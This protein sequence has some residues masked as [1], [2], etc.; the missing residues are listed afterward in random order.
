MDQKTEVRG[1]SVKLCVIL[2]TTLTIRS[3][4]CIPSPTFVHFFIKSQ[5]GVFTSIP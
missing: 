4:H 2:N 5:E 3:C 1:E